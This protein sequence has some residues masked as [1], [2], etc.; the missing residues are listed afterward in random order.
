MRSHL[1]FG[2]LAQISNRYRL[3]KL[4]TKATRKIHR[5]NT[6]LQDTINE[7]FIRVQGTNPEAQMAARAPTSRSGWCESLG[8][9][10]EAE[11]RGSFPPLELS[12][13]VSLE[14]LASYAAER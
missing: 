9:L 12:D 3:C 4:A 2:A 11:F 6:R 7:V 14:E 13:D 8:R 1:V 10:D 5:P